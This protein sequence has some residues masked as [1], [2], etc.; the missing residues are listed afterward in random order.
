M[1]QENLYVSQIGENGGILV[2]EDLS[3]AS[4]SQDYIPGF[5]I[6]QVQNGKSRDL[7]RV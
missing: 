1:N 3:E 4:A 7:R 6:P 2:L 5:T